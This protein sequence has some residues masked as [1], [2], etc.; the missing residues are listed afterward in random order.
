MEHKAPFY[1]IELTHST[2]SLTII[3]TYPYRQGLERFV[4]NR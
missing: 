1:A 4:V 3:R 2:Q